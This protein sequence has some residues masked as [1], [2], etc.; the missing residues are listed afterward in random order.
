MANNAI[1]PDAREKITAALKNYA[2]KHGAVKRNDL[3]K[4]AIDCL[5]LK[6]AQLQDKSSE[7]LYCRYRSLTGSIINDLIR[8]GSIKIKTDESQDGKKSEKPGRNQQAI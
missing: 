4:P 6:P 7:S 5:G 1:L 3:F 8:A 2:K